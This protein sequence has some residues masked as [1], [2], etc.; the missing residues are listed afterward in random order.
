[1]KSEKIMDTNNHLIK[2]ADNLDKNQ[3]SA[4][5][6]AVDN[7]IKQNSL[8]KVAQYVGAIGYVLKQERAMSNCIR[9]KRV[10]NSGSMQEVVLG[11]LKEY[12]DG[13]DYH[14]TEWTSKYAQLVKKLPDKFSDIHVNFLHK[15]ADQNNMSQHIYNIEST[16]DSLKKDGV[17]DDYI[18]N[19]LSHV[20]ELE[21]ILSK[22]L[23][24]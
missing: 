1:M 10:A 19:I 4:S 2:L 21:F 3:K 11:C 20:Y 5:A 23:N 7:L 8:N 13:Q 18:N 6:D 12:Q 9:R 17:N 15:I 14:D 22:D 24:K 16:A